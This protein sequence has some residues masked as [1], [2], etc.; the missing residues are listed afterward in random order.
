MLLGGFFFGNRGPFRVADEEGMVGL[1]RSRGVRVVSGV[2]QAESF[3]V[4]GLLVLVGIV[5]L[6]FGAALDSKAELI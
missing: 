1:R 3:N 4:S 5:L 2:E 6:A